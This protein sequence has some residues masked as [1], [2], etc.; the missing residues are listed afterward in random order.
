MTELMLV[1]RGVAFLRVGSKRWSRFC[2][3]TAHICAST[4]HI[5]ASTA[6]N[7]ERHFNGVG[8]ASAP[9]ESPP[10]AAAALPRTA[11]YMVQVQRGEY[12]S[13]M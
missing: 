4:A 13:R 9:L 7:S 2:A 11:S 6:H 12:R 1:E 8:G 5:C 3:S 10:L